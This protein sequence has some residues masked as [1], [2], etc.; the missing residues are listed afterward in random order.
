MLISNIPNLFFDYFDLF[1]NDEWG[2]QY[3]KKKLPKVIQFHFEL[4][5]TPSIIITIIT[6]EGF[7]Q[8]SYLIR[9]MI[10]IINYLFIMKI[11]IM[12][13]D[14][15]NGA[16]LVLLTS[17]TSFSLSLTLTLKLSTSANSTTKRLRCSFSLFWRAASSA[18][19]ILNSDIS[20]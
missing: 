18:Y 20:S 3:Q 16:K 10:F 15:L 13:H 17:S 11:F 6:C 5:S 7:I 4:V 12:Y 14:I 1:D 19:L 2:S 8:L 9:L